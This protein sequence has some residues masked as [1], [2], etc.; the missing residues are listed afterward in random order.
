M[1]AAVGSEPVKRSVVTSQRASAEIVRVAERNRFDLVVL[2]S[3]G[4]SEP[5]EYL[6]GSTA[7]RV[8]QLCPVPVLVLKAL[9]KSLLADA[10]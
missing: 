3:H 7:K 9:G 4:M 1:E 2:P 6:F 5:G 10:G 8:V